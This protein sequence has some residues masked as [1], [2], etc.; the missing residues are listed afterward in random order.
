MSNILDSIDNGDNDYLMHL[1]SAKIN[2]I[3]NKKLRAL[4]LTNKQIVDTMKILNN[5]RFIDDLN[6]IRIGSYIRW[7][8]NDL[9]LN[10]GAIVVCIT[11]DGGIKCKG[12]RGNMFHLIDYIYIFQR[13]TASELTIISA[14]NY[15]V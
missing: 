15:L 5:Y 6:T 7:I 4:P 9:I 10:K 14:L 2:A 1:T 3:M 8:N 13:L 12:F 11:E